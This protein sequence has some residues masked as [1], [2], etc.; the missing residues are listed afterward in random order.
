MTPVVFTRQS[1]YEAIGTMSGARLAASGLTG[2]GTYRWPL[3]FLVNLRAT[4]SYNFE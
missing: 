3:V 2:A 4:A 1:T